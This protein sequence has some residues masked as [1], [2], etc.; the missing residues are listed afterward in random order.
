MR[1]QHEQ[2]NVSACNHDSGLLVQDYPA[3]SR[4]LRL[5][6]VTETYPPEVNGVALTLSHLVQ[7][8]HARNHD[9]QLIR[10]RQPGS[11]ASGTIERFHEV[12]MRSIAVPR[13]PSLRMG[14]PS[15]RALVKLWSV[16]RPDLVHI[17]T[18]GPLGWSA[19]KACEQL[20]LPVTSDFR[21]NFHAYSQHYG[22]G[23][24]RK[25]IT[26]YLRKF[27]NASFRT[28]VPT[29]A[30]LDELHRCGFINLRVVSRGVDMDLFHPARRDSHLRQQWAIQDDGLAVVCVGRLAAEKN[31]ELLERT[32]DAIAARVPHAKLILVGDGPARS[33]LQDRRQ[34]FHFAGMR[35]GED[36]A[37]HVASTD[38]FLFPS[39]T[40]TFGN[41]VTEALASGVPVVAFD[42]AAAGQLIRPGFNG[43]RVPLDDDQAFVN[44]AVEAAMDRISLGRWA[45][46]ARDSVRALDWHG[47]VERFE[48]ELLAALNQAQK[49]GA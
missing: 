45:S 29:Q 5:A 21:T 14:V 41:V 43:Q 1:M 31:L 18:E 37:R 8:M 48:S 12:L 32:F 46:Q 26:A 25:P 17:A 47:V 23:W 11:D 6:V 2:M 27:H 40:E 24:L 33:A 15:K 16:N 30:L 42:H 22:V 3:R 13:Y 4:S 38:L 19:L 34:D 20:K 7:G 39:K 44:A 49:A 28:F 35:S 36:L 10:P 9:V